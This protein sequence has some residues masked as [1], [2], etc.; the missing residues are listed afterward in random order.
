MFN[1]NKTKKFLNIKILFIILFTFNT[2]IY[3]K[4]FQ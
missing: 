4:Y 1:N 3:N 2:I